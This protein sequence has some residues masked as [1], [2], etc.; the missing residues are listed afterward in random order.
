MVAEG[1][2]RLKDLRPGMAVFLF[3]PGFIKKQVEPG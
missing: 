1:N 2:K 3:Y